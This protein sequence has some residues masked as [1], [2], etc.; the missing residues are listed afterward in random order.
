MG[1][2]VQG[3]LYVCGGKRMNAR[4]RK[5]PK[6]TAHGGHVEP[7]GGVWRVGEWCARE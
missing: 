2:L 6:S 4:H 1:L 5:S 7:V 3:R